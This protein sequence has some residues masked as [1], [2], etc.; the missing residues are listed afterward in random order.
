MRNTLRFFGLLDV[1]SIVLFAPQFWLLLTNFNKLVSNIPTL[2]VS[3]LRILLF[4]SL[5]ISA[6]G[7]L[8]LKKFG[9]ITYYIQFIFRFITLILSF[10]FITY[11]NDFITAPSI[12]K[13]TLTLAVFGE[14]LRIYF[15]YKAQKSIY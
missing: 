10:G 9:T 4:L 1:I 15:T 12:V 5:F 14:F 11:V 3:S 8:L 13:T 7:L 2:A 6:T